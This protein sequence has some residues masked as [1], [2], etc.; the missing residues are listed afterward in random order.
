[1]V[2]DACFPLGLVPELVESAADAV[3]AV[4]DRL[5][6]ERSLGVHRKSIERLVAVELDSTLAE[7]QRGGRFVPLRG[8][9]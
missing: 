5:P 4:E 6:L 8:G 1:V 3:E 2:N 7:R 9:L